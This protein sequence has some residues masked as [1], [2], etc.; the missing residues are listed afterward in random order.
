ME[1]TLL[2]GLPLWTINL[3]LAGVV[4]C[5]QPRHLPN[6]AFAVFVLTVVAWA[7]S[8]QILYVESVATTTLWWKRLPFAAAS[9]IGTSFAVF[10]ETF[11]DLKSLRAR[12]ISQAFIAL[13]SLV[14]WL[15]LSPLIV[16]ETSLSGAGNI[17]PHYGPLYP[18]FGLFRSPPSDMA[19]GTWRGNGGRLAAAAGCRS[20]ICGW[21]CAGPSWAARPPI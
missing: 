2:T 19:F 5:R 7:F 6:Q 20:S 17:Q 10:C 9:L 11:P 8:V 4:F 16:Y 12:R 13:G 1:T 3:F 18:V 15:S 14:A 21:V